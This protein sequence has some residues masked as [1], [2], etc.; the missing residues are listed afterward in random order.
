MQVKAVDPR[1]AFAQANGRR[2]HYSVPAAVLADLK[3]FANLAKEGKAVTFNGLRQWMLEKHTLVLGRTRLI[4][5]CKA[6]GVEL[7][8]K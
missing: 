8:L 1:E 4:S 5:V 2:S 3:F 7:W 6:N